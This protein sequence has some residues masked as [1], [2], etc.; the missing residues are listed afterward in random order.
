[1]AEIARAEKPKLKQLKGPC[2]Q[3]V[4]KP[5]Q[6]AVRTWLARQKRN[7]G[8]GRMPE[9]IANIGTSFANDDFDQDIPF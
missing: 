4:A 6:S 2:N 5:I 8:A 3:T 9:R 7:N 1:M